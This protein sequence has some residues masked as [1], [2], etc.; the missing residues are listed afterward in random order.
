M[1]MNKPPPGI[2]TARFKTGWAT[3]DILRHQAEDSRSDI[4]ENKKSG[5]RT[6]APALIRY[7]HTEPFITIIGKRFLLSATS[8]SAMIRK[9]RAASPS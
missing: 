7:L 6:A 8:P 5:S 3:P 2:R 9:A 1:P 4:D